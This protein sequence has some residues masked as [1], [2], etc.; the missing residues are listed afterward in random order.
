MVRQLLFSFFLG[1]GI[2][3]ISCST[4]KITDSDSEVTIDYKVTEKKV[5]ADSISLQVQRMEAGISRQTAEKNLEAVEAP[6]PSFYRLTVG[7]DKS[8]LAYIPSLE[9]G[10]GGAFSSRSSP[11]T[12]ENSYKFKDSSAVYV[13]FSSKIPGV[14]MKV[15]N[16]EFQWKA[17]DKDTIISGIKAMLF[18]GTNGNSKIKAWVTRQFPKELSAY[19]SFSPHGF[20]LAYELETADEPPFKIQTIKVYPQKIRSTPGAEIKAPQWSKEMNRQEII[21]QLNVRNSQ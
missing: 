6:D 1:F 20:I 19:D 15:Q 17:A 21:R 9:M 14:V 18:A 12:Q 4:S 13:D 7:K 11:F 16:Q 3:F 8:R 10:E 5:F 2:I